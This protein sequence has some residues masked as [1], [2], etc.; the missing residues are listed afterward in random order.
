MY[1]NFFL[2]NYLFVSFVTRKCFTLCI[3]YVPDN[4]NLSR[5]VAVG[6][7]LGSRGLVAV[8]ES[9]AEPKTKVLGLFELS[10]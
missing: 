9:P 4:V 10:D 7:S 1:D 2:I 3:H 6:G 5:R 8:K